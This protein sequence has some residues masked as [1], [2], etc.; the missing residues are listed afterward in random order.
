[1]YVSFSVSP[2]V[3][4]SLYVSPPPS[5]FLTLSLYLSPFSLILSPSICL[6]LSPSLSLFLSH[7]ICLSFC[8]NSL[9]CLFLSLSLNRILSVSFL[10]S[11]YVSLGVSPLSFSMSLFFSICLSSVSFFYPPP[12]SASPQIFGAGTH[13]GCWSPSVTC[14]FEV[15]ARWQRNV[16]PPPRSFLLHN[17]PEEHMWWNKQLILAALVLWSVINIT[18]VGKRFVI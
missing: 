11:L 6:L 9:F 7:T 1:M 8:S 3:C 13:G 5:L 15:V 12:S 2:S 16:I 17:K 4:L 14:S 10:S 18:T